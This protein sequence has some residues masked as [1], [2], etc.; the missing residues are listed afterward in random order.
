[1]ATILYVDDEQAIGNAVQSWLERRGVSVHRATSVESARHLVA[2]HQFDG[3][4]IDVWLGDGTGFELF[5]HIA[6]AQPALA[7][8]V[9]FI[10]GDAVP[11]DDVAR[12]LAEL[13][14]PVIAK[15]FDLSTLDGWVATWSAP[16]AREPGAAS[17]ESPAAARGAPPGG[18]DD[19][20]HLP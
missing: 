9:A 15:P 5:D 19:T 16:A 4:F 6:E 1:M 2:R 8:R 12:R 3:A 10:T 17:E 7:G 18:A 11:R 13:D 14:R 20:T